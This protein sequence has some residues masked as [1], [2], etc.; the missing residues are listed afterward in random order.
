MLSHHFVLLNFSPPHSQLE[1]A[2][3]VQV[4]VFLFLGVDVK[5]VD[6]ILGFYLEFLCVF[7]CATFLLGFV[8]FNF[9]GGVLSDEDYLFV[10]FVVDMGEFV[11]YFFVHWLL[12]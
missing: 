9:S 12:F 8:C 2:F 5:Q 10:A 6:I 11:E 7:D 3:F 1:D 4:D